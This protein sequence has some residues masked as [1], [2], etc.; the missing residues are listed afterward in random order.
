MFN[1]AVIESRLIRDI[2]QAQNFK[3]LRCLRD[4]NPFLFAVSD[5]INT[6]YRLQERTILS[7]YK[8]KKLKC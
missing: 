5:M 4:A 7:I 6:F 2:L 1:F 8:L 3:K